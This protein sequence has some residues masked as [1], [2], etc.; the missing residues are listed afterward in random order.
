M[1]AQFARERTTTAIL[2]IACPT[3]LPTAEYPRRGPSGAEPSTPPRTT[4]SPPRTPG[5]P[6]VPVV[7]DPIPRFV[8]KLSRSAAQGARSKQR[9]R[10]RRSVRQR[11]D[12]PQPPLPH[13]RHHRST[14]SHA[15]SPC[16]PAHTDP[17]RLPPKTP[18]T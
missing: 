11:H 7:R 12:S 15:S 8:R 3:T 2:L 10:D 4:T 13:R 1:L 17:H 18:T 5:L 9:S 16:A 6:L 14:S